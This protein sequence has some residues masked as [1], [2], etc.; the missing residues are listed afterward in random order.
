MIAEPDPYVYPGTRVLKNRLG[1]TNTK[2]FDAVEYRVT[3]PRRQ[4]LELSPVTGDFD[5]RHLLDIH[6]R[7]FQ[8]LFE[9]A[10]QLRTIAMSKGTSTFYSSSNWQPAADHTFGYL[11]DGPLLRGDSMS[12]AVFTENA[13][14]LLN[15]TNYI[16]PFREGNGRAQRAFL[17]QIAR[18]SGRRLSWRNVGRMEH[19]RAA[20][21]SFNSASGKPFEPLIA[22][23]LAAPLDGLSP[24]DDDVYQIIGPLQP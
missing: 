5:L 7:L 8:D 10:G 15:R 14:E 9:W 4:E 24:F 2:E 23:I 21:E 16:H 20:I 18:L 17:D 12:N 3:W 13:A 11:H 22:K 19:T 6:R 1:I